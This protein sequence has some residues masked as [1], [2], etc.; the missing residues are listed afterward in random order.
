MSPVLLQNLSMKSGITCQLCSCTHTQK[1]L[2]QAKEVMMLIYRGKRERHFGSSISE[3]HLQGARRR[4][5][6]LKRLYSIMRVDNGLCGEFLMNFLMYFLLSLFMFNYVIFLWCGIW[7]LRCF[8]DLWFFIR[9][10]GSTTTSDSQEET[11]QKAEY[12]WETRKPDVHHL[13]MRE[14]PRDR[15][16]KF[17]VKLLNRNISLL[18]NSIKAA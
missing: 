18:P 16:R 3:V 13:C 12:R 1:R 2:N 10:M 6:Q 15:T 14:F 4:T 5:P 9:A 17:K 7:W 11:I 8:H